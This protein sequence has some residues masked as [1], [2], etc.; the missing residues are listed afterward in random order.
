V[1]D[2][3]FG[4]V[5]RRT[6]IAVLFTLVLANQYFSNPLPLDTSSV[7]RLFASLIILTGFFYIGR[8][9]VRLGIATSLAILMLPLYIIQDLH[10]K[11]LY[12]D[13]DYG[14]SASKIRNVFIRVGYTLIVVILGTPLMAVIRV[15]RDFVLNPVFSQIDWGI[16]QRKILVDRFNNSD[17]SQIIPY[18]DYKLGLMA[19]LDRLGIIV[20][21][22][23][24]TLPAYAQTRTNWG[25]YGL[26][27]L[28]GTFILTSRFTLVVLDAI[29]KTE[30]ENQK[31]AGAYA[32]KYILPP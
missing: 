2:F 23:F 12:Y 14:K 26:I 4:L 13:W 17:K 16:Y 6:V 27:L 3:G 28:L 31:D 8:I 10:R 5:D 11:L 19:I 30:I 1:T 25:V 18:Q 32:K 15:I 20:I 29:H 24:S 21:A 7:D 22:Y 9:I